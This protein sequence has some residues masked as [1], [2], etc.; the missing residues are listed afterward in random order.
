MGRTLLLCSL[1]TC[2]CGSWL[3]Y[4]ELALRHPGYVAR[5]AMDMAIVLICVGTRLWHLGIRFER[6]LR[7]GGVALIGIAINALVN[8]G[9]RT[10]FEGFVVI[11]S[12]ALLLQGVMMLILLGRFTD[13]P[14]QR[15]S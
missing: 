15:F 14:R 12:G 13:D 6:W 4:A 2:M 9:R 10:H 5:L 1:M 3:S 11:V 7:V 8:N